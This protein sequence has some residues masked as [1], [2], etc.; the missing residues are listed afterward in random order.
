MS[1][2]FFLS[3]ALR[4]QLGDYDAVLLDCPPQ[5]GKL[6]PN[7]LFAADEVLVP[8]SMVD[9]GAYNGAV[10]LLARIDA[11][12]KRQA[13]EVAAIVRTHVDRRRRTFRALD[14]EVGELGAPVART[15]IPLRS[16]FNDAGVTGTPVV[17]S[18][19][20]SEGAIAYR[21]LGEELA[22]LRLVRK[23]A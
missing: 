3:D 12:R 20:D 6:T 11:V 9:R 16:A 18:S 19:P 15:L 22:G 7:A 21:N 8:V 10:E 2:E 13:L 1:A 23:A 14:G 5:L 17:V 4:D